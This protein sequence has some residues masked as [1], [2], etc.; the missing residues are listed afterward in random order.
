MKHIVID[1][2]ISLEK[3]EKFLKECKNLPWA[4]TTGTCKD[5]PY[6]SNKIFDVGQLVHQIFYNEHKS[7]YFSYITPLLVE[8]SKHI[9]VTTPVRFKANLL[10]RTQESQGRWTT[11]HQDV[12]TLLNNDNSH[13]SA[14]YYINDSDGDTCLFYEDMPTRITPKQGR[15]VIFPS[16]VIH[17]SS[18]PVESYQ[19][20]VFNLVWKTK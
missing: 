5:L 20:V 15:V 19:R 8:I 17:A 4:Y 11:P 14:V 3:Q 9:P 12:S 1:D 7:P 6:E 13:W 16:N 18:N 10:W 2:I